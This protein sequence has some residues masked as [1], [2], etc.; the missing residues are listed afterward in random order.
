MMNKAFPDDES[1][2]LWNS[3][4]EDA[5][6]GK[7]F[8]RTTV[9]HAD[10]N[11]TVVKAYNCPSCSAEVMTESVTLAAS[12]CAFCG[13]PVTITERLL[14]GRSLPSRV[15]PFAVTREGAFDVYK[16]KL[17]NRPL[18]PK[19]FRENIAPPD[20]KAVYV[21]FML[22]DVECSA[23]ITAKGV[24]T[25]SW[26]DHNYNY[27]KTD[28]YEA[29]RYGAMD[30]AQVPEDA[31]DKIDNEKMRG[32]EPFKMEELTPFS[33]KYLSGHFAEAPTT[34]EGELRN[35]LFKRLE[36]AAVRTMLNTV[37]GYDRVSLTSGSVSVDKADSE[38]VMLPAWLF[39]T[40]Y[41]DKEFMYAINGQ[42]GKFTG[43][44][45]VD[46]KTA[47][48]LFLKLALIVFAVMFICLEVY[49]WVS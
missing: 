17:K 5:Q 16:S 29:R 25:T 28:T 27:T 31:S 3:A 14:S 13:N 9:L 49:L 8:E 15:I 26:S 37:T 23:A 24:N 34:K 2:T 39:L 12:S 18:I 42:T 11:E 1:G 4:K 10:E 36:P 38:Y 32:I 33:Q 44:F 41:K 46:W 19:I 40:R 43:S 21:P 48:L 22:Y 6:T 45:P 47:G 20:L 7:A 35:S 30:F